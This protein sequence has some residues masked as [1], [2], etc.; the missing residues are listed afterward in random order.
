M[1]GAI[2]VHISMFAYAS[3]IYKTAYSEMDCSLVRN[4]YYPDNPDQELEID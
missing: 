2:P 3:Y 4:V 1:G